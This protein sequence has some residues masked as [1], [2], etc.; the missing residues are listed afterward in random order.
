[1]GAT[2][3]MARARGLG[4]RGHMG[5]YGGHGPRDYL[6]ST[7]LVHY[8]PFCTQTLP[9]SM[10]EK[11]KA[12]NGSSTAVPD[13]VAGY[14]LLANC[15]AGLPA[16]SAQLLQ[17]LDPKGAL[18]LSS[19]CRPLRSSLRFAAVPSVHLC[20]LMR[21]AGPASHS[22]GC[23]LSVTVPWGRCYTLHGGCVYLLAPAAFPVP[24]T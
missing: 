10:P 7:V 1:M 2:G 23:E 3:A 8:L 13:A 14:E 12:R 15:W 19:T 17:C 9:L 18:R 24:F 11:K 4:D 16:V 5:G 21:Q 20:L 22:D 6:P